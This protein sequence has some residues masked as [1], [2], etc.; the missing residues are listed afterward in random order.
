MASNVLAGEN[1]DHAMNAR[2]SKREYGRELLMQMEADK[3]RRSNEAAFVSNPSEA[4]L[5]RRNVAEDIVLPEIQKPGAPPQ[6]RNK[7]GEGRPRSRHNDGKER[8][9]IHTPTGRPDEKHGQR[10]QVQNILELEAQELLLGLYG[11]VS[12]MEKDLSSASRDNQQL[13]ERMMAL[14][15]ENASLRADNKMLAPHEKL[16]QLERD[17]SQRL[18]AHFEQMTTVESEKAAAALRRMNELQ[19]AADNERR[20]AERMREALEQQTSLMSEMEKRLHAVE[21]AEASILQHG[22][23]QVEHQASHRREVEIKLHELEQAIRAMRNAGDEASRGTE[24]AVREMLESNHHSLQERMKQ[25]LHALQL[26]LNN[27]QQEVEEKNSSLLV[28]SQAEGNAREQY[29]QE[30]RRETEAKLTDL[31]GRMNELL[32]SVEQSER[33]TMQRLEEMSRRSEEATRRLEVAAGEQEEHNSRT[34]KQVR[35]ELRELSEEATESWEKS[36]SFLEEVVRAEIR[37]RMKGQEELAQRLSFLEAEAGR[38]GS[39]DADA[40]EL[41]AS[42]RLLQAKSSSQSKSIKTLLFDLS[43]EVKQREEAGEE[44]ARRIAAVEEELDELRRMMGRSAMARMQ[45]GKDA[46]EVMESRMKALESGR[47]EML[48]RMQAEMEGRR[49]AE[50][51][52]WRE[53]GSRIDALQ[54]AVDACVDLCESDTRELHEEMSRMEQRVEKETSELEGIIERTTRDMIKSLDNKLK[55]SMQEAVAS[56]AGSLRRELELQGDRISQVDH[57]QKAARTESR[58]SSRQVEG[59]IKGV[60]QALEEAEQR[61]NMVL[62]RLREEVARVTE[63]SGKRVALLEEGVHEARASCDVWSTNVSQRCEEVERKVA[64]LERDLFASSSGSGRLERWHEESKGQEIDRRGYQEEGGGDSGGVVGEL[65][66]KLSKTRDLLLKKLEDLEAHQSRQGER[67]EQYRKEIDEAATRVG[68]RVDHALTEVRGDSTALHRQMEEER[69]L[70]QQQL[71]DIRKMVQAMQEE[72]STTLQTEMERS[73]EEEK[74]RLQAVLSRVERLEEEVNGEE[75]VKYSIDMLAVR[76]DEQ[77]V[78]LVSEFQRQHAL[79]LELASDTKIELE[80]QERRMEE[81]SEA[82]RALFEQAREEMVVERNERQE[83]VRKVDEHVEHVEEELGQVRK[84]LGDVEGSLRASQQERLREVEEEMEK[85]R[86]MVEEIRR[87]LEALA[88]E[89]ECKHVMEGMLSALVVQEQEEKLRIAIGEAR[90]VAAASLQTLE[91]DL[92]E[93]RL[94]QL[95]KE[96]IQEMVTLKL[97]PLS[98]DVRQAEVNI[99]D[100][101]LQT[102][103]LREDVDRKVDVL[104]DRIE[105]LLAN[106][107]STSSNS[108]TAERRLGELA[109]KLVEMAEAMKRAGE[110]SEDEAVRGKVDDLLMAVEM[111]HGHEDVRKE[112]LLRMQ[113]LQTSVEVL[114]KGVESVEELR[115]NM[116]SSSEEITSIRGRIDEVDKI[117]ESLSE[118]VMEEG[119]KKGVEETSSEKDLDAASEGDELLD[120]A[121]SQLDTVME[122]EEQAA[123]DDAKNE[124]P[125]AGGGEAGPEAAQEE[126]RESAQ[127][128]DGGKEESKDAEIGEEGK[129]EG[130]P[131]TLQELGPEEVQQAGDESVRKE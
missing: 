3:Q 112:L 118:L 16:L 97:L 80:K 86:R 91:S 58:G 70:N 35:K 75:G 47:E 29:E 8:R 99:S 26:D 121:S 108:Q 21:A 48:R 76:L 59:K 44:A 45:E 12:A 28:R 11:K 62:G 131:E 107:Q 18:H 2:R 105:L 34:V 49:G 116:V 61:I 46:Q 4:N 119:G 77:N 95:I 94:P 128:E 110:R 15:V 5:R 71:S 17:L 113:G 106:L 92:V 22:A 23:S 10:A 33:T 124:R 56:L 72:M 84:M 25:T 42:V 73:E 117:V 115:R 129:R 54:R 43:Q 114:S 103:N 96:E 85:I 37:G 50:A 125:D 6:E 98:Q 111:L 38:E 14:E 1:P 104:S 40:G 36:R 100:Q 51:E 57:E 27:V 68:S 109:D 82:A 9:E 87:E 67:L 69:N 13:R 93:E 123:E 64:K 55:A 120:P 90:S 81:G 126:P 74:K 79:H 32:R 41:Q 52:R 53:M 19:L 66:V 102:Q 127:G 20:Q 83:S 30:V 39:K 65:N 130:L 24:E 60:E 7:R 31:Y 122:E 78:E 88:R 89:E 101:E 63:R